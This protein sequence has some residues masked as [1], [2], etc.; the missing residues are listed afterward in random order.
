M[1]SESVLN[2]NELTEQVNIRP[3]D[4]ARIIETGEL[5]KTNL[6]AFIASIDAEI[7]KA[8]RAKNAHRVGELQRA[9]EAWSV[10]HDQLTGD[11]RVDAEMVRSRGYGAVKQD[12]NLEVPLPFIHQ[13][14]FKEPGG[15]DG[16]FD[17]LSEIYLKNFIDRESDLVDK[18][19][20]DDFDDRLASAAPILD[21]MRRAD[22]VGWAPPSKPGFKYVQYDGANQI[23]PSVMFQSCREFDPE[24]WDAINRRI[25]KGVEAWEDPRFFTAYAA[26][27][28]NWLMSK[29]DMRTEMTWPSK[30][31]M[32]ERGMMTA[33]I[34]EHD[35]P[36]FFV[37][38]DMLDAADKTDV[39]HT[40][41]W[42]HLKL[43][44]EGA[45]FVMPRGKLMSPR[46]GSINF[47][48]Y[49]R[50][51]GDKIYKL[52]GKGARINTDFDHFMMCAT[53]TEKMFDY[54]RVF[55]KPVFDARTDFGPDS[56]IATQF[57]T[58]PKEQQRDARL[59][60]LYTPADVEFNDR[61]TNILFNLLLL[62]EARPEIISKE[63]S[64]RV[65]YHKK[66]RCEL[67]SPNILGRG[68]RIGRPTPTDPT[69]DKGTHAS[70]RWHW[71]RGHWREQGYGPISCVDCGC[72]HAAHDREDKRCRKNE[73]LAVQCSGR[74]RHETYERY[75]V[76]PMLVN[77]KEDINN[78]GGKLRDAA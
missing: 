13:G 36:M 50:L 68:Y 5:N 65:G 64:R 33:A 66:R 22:A 75:W 52:P 51:Y 17:S 55:K 41:H 16:R 37:S 19:T 21:T 59:H 25:Y 38:P 46:G 28:V 49:A 47:I 69:A 74:Y 8:L 18:F 32:L 6:G 2:L 62:M 61:C 27:S 4:L 58:D 31:G 30:D 56:T 23:R 53:D 72:A 14:R 42:K 26:S 20:G 12:H 9:R 3:E 71:R 29:Y 35:V 70:P 44:H 45:V 54:N 11:H 73:H 78:G 77:Y 60:P 15:Q 43:P 48:A 34:A 10:F 1:A 57:S 7:R 39:P 76:A 67:W 40:V 24:V 63:G